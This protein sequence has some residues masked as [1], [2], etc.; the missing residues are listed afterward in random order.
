MTCIH[1]SANKPA[2]G[3]CPTPSPFP[4]N[5]REV[6]EL[7]PHS[8]SCLSLPI[9]PG[10]VIH[11]NRI[12]PGHQIRVGPEHRNRQCGKEIRA[13]NYLEHGLEKGMG[14]R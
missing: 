8:T 12:D 11:P 6:S 7:Q 4:H 9:G 5:V 10:V 3:P 14:F 2:L 1:S 13:P